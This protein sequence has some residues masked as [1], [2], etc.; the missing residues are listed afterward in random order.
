MLYDGEI[1]RSNAMFLIAVS[2]KYKRKNH[3]DSGEEWDA[4]LNLVKK[5]EV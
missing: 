2:T 5:Y 4:D 3:D 1:S